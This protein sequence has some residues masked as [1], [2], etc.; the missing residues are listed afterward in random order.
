MFGDM[1]LRYDSNNEGFS[2][3]QGIK[4]AQADGRRNSVSELPFRGTDMHFMAT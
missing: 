4:R 2:P 1:E 3:R